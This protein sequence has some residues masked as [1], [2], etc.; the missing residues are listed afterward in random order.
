MSKEEIQFWI[1]RWKSLE[2]S[3]KRDMV[4]KIWGKLVKQR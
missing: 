2:P 4:I 3:P 1:D